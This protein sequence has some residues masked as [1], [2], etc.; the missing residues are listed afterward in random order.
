MGKKR[1]KHN[2]NSRQMQPQN[3][4]GGARVVALALL[5]L[6]GGVFLYALSQNRAPKPAVTPAPSSVAAAPAPAPGQARTYRYFDDLDDARPFPA[7]LAPERF[8]HPVVSKAYAI[9]RQIPGVLAQQPCLCGCD[10]PSD[11]HRSLLDCYA[12]EH[13]A[14]CDVCIKE[15]VYAKKMTD[16]GKSAAW[17][18]DAIVRHE[19]S[20]VDVGN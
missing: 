16:A 19:F 13:A 8:Q 17:I 20:N 18:R 5:A 3:A 6:G 7:T 4:S 14:T 11:D 1:G 10:N 2:A 15:A 12:D 9:A